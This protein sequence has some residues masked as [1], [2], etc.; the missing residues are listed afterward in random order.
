VLAHDLEALR[1]RRAVTTPGGVTAQGLA[2]LERGGVRPA[3]REAL[4][5]VLGRL[6]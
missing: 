4:D 1:V 2:A 6:G 3:F 5:A